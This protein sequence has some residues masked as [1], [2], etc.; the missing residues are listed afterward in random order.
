MVSSTL[1]NI[2]LPCLIV[3]VLSAGVNKGTGQT[4]PPLFVATETVA[5][6]PRTVMDMSTPS[7]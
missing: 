2:T 3:T 6:Y 5:L 1:P 7:L 4:M